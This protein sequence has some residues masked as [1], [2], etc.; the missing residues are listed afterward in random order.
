MKT[1]A[2]GGTCACVRA[3]RVC[4]P[5]RTPLQTRGE[6]VEALQLRAGFD[7]TGTVYQSPDD[8]EAVY[9]RMTTGWFENTFVRFVSDALGDG[10][11]VYY[12]GRYYQ[13]DA[14]Y[15][16]TKRFPAA[17]MYVGSLQTIEADFSR[18]TILKRTRQICLGKGKSLPIRMTAGICSSLCKLLR[19]MT[20]TASAATATSVRERKTVPC[21]HA[22]YGLSCNQKNFRHRSQK[23]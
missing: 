8:P 16:M 7:A 14:G 11:H 2:S 1:R 6:P 18:R 13:C 19:R 12:K 3:T 10:G 20:R 22:W 17:Y 4:V 23:A 15:E 5:S 21:D 9:V